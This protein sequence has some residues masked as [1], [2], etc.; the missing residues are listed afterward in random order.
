[1]FN[2][3]PGSLGVQK[4]FEAVAGG[5][6]LSFSAGRNQKFITMLIGMWG[7]NEEFPSNDKLQS[8]MGELGFVSSSVLEEVL[9]EKQFQSLKK[10]LN[11]YYKELSDE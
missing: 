6:R 10:K 11:K 5:T 2:L 7:K 3:R 9:T 8:M 1:M 4:K